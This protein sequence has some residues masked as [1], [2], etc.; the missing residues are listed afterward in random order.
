MICYRLFINDFIYRIIQ[1]F[2]SKEKFNEQLLVIECKINNQKWKFWYINESNNEQLM[3]SVRKFDA[4][5]Y[6]YN[7]INIDPKD[8]GCMTIK[9]FLINEIKDNKINIFDLEKILFHII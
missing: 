6:M 5:V 3:L 1:Y 7:D 2:K 9:Q 8:I 4:T